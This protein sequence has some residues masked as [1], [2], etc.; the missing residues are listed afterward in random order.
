MSASLAY[1]VRNV[2]DLAFSKIGIDGSNTESVNVTLAH[3]NLNLLLGLWSCDPDMAIA[4]MVP[5]S[6]YTE[7]TDTI[8]IP[9]EYI[10]ALVPNLAVFM[11]PDF[12]QPVD[13]A[14]AAA[15]DSAV[16]MIKIFNIRRQ[17]GRIPPNGCIR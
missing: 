10:A 16:S 7:L 2:I 3:N 9:P 17:A 12:D 15:A 4:R 13:K 11:S 14:L 5:L 8:D 1:T 6:G